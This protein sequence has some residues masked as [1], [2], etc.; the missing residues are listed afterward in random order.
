MGSRLEGIP[1]YKTLTTSVPASMYNEVRLA[2]LRLNDTIRFPITGLRTLQLIL[3]KDTWVVVDASLND[4]PVLAWTGFEAVQRD[5]LHEP[6]SCKL[7]MYHAHATIIVDVVLRELHKEL[8]N[9]LHAGLRVCE[10]E[11]L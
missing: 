4:V 5:N 2:L 9:R 3:D 10:V 6:I 1:R 7:Y 11:E 8:D